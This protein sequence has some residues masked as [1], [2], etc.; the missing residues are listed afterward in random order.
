MNAVIEVAGKIELMFE[1][2]FLPKDK[3]STSACLFCI[4]TKC[5]KN[6]VLSLMRQ[7]KGL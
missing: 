2:L 1:E 4:N 5:L 7:T 6:K 3:N